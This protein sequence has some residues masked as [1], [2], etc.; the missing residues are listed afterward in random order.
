MK[1]IDGMLQ[2]TFTLAKTC[3]LAVQDM[4]LLLK[5]I[6]KGKP[7]V[8]NLELYHS[9]VSVKQ[10]TVCAMCVVGAIV[11]QSGV[12]DNKSWALSELLQDGEINSFILYSRLKLIDLLRLGRFDVLSY[13]RGWFEN[14]NEELLYYPTDT[15]KQICK[16]RIKKKFCEKNLLERYIDLYDDYAELFDKQGL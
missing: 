11:R 13:E 12:S 8:F 15:V 7:L 5:D 3:R 10:K 1:D 9:M 4:R 16:K 6:D 14:K 2:K